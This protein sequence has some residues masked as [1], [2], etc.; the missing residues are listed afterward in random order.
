MARQQQASDVEDA[1]DLVADL[2]IRNVPTILFF[3]GG[4]VVDKLVGAASKPKLDEKFAA[5]L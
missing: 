2:G 3:K 1:E 5:L 4:E